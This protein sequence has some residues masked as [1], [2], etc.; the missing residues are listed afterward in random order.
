MPLDRVSTWNTTY[1][2]QNSVG[3]E[4]MGLLITIIIFILAAMALIYLISSTE[5]F[6]T[7]FKAFEYIIKSVKYA[8][9]GTGVSA[10]VYGTYIVVSI[11]TS[12]ASEG[13]FDPMVL[14]YGVGIYIVLSGIGWVSEKVAIKIKERHAEYQKNRGERGEER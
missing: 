13:A 1:S 14:V 8:L 10:V 5:R 3:V 6:A 11:L 12:A 4:S 7:I 2:V 9:Y